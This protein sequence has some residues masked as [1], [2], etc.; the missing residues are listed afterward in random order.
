MLIYLD[1]TVS[2]HK[3]DGSVENFK[4]TKIRGDVSFKEQN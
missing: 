4:K 1:K 2:K 3:Y